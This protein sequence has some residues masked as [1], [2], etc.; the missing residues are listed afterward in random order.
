MILVNVLDL[1]G[2][3]I[4][5]KKADVRCRESDGSLRYREQQPKEIIVTMKVAQI[6]QR[7]HRTPTKVDW[8]YWRYNASTEPNGHSCGYSGARLDAFLEQPTF[9][10]MEAL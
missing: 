10:K 4:A 5:G 1:V 3:N 2:E 9:I 6:E 7:K 8:L